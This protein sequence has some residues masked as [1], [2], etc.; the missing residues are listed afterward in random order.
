MKRL[1]KLA[2]KDNWLFAVW[3][4]KSGT[5]IQGI[6]LTEN[7]TDEVGDWEFDIGGGGVS[8]QKAIALAMVEV[9]EIESGEE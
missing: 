3:V 7:T 8:L 2:K 9:K 1:E 6:R 4:K 5:I